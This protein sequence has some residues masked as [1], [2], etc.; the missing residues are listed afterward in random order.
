MRILHIDIETAPNKGYFWG[1]WGQNIAINQIDEPGYTLCWAAKWHGAKE[2]MF[3][4]VY[5]S[6]PRHMLERVHELLDE[7]DVVCHYNGKKFDIPT[8]NREFFM[9]EMPPPSPFKQIDLLQT[10]R[11]QFRFASNKLDYVAQQLGIGSKINH[12]GMEMWKD[13][14]NKCPK[15]WKIM[16]RYN[17]QDVKLTEKYYNRL[18]PWIE[19][20]PN[21]GL[22]LDPERPTCRN[23]GSNKMTK[24]G[25][26]RTTTL[27]YDRYQCGKCGK[28]GRGR[29]RLHKTPHG[30]TV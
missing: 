13:C 3:D 11:R 28:W 16:K 2:V 17:I 22:Y 29:E 12:M 1:L 8:L 19:N 4:S 25:V 24:R 23:C 15:A 10:T 9:L 18:L 14:M 26:A 27:T 30:L 5:D 21:W 6:K 7:A 20:H